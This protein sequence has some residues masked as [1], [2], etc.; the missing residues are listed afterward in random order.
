MAGNQEATSSNKFLP[1][2]AGELLLFVLGSFLF[3]PVLFPSLLRY[4]ITTAEDFGASFLS[5]PLLGIQVVI[6][7]VLLILIPLLLGVHGS[8]LNFP[9]YSVLPKYF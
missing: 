5:L 9:S 6:V 7:A 4:F 8:T 2:L 3:I 1:I